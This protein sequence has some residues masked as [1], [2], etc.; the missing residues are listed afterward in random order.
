VIPCAFVEVCVEVV[1]LR[2]TTRVSGSAYGSGHAHPSTALTPL[3]T[4]VDQFP[5][6]GQMVIVMLRSE[7]QM[8]HQP[9]RLL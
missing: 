9:H 1:G 3:L 8:V 6:F 2:S 7:I 4:F 5:D